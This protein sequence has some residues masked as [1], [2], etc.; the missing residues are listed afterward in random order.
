MPGYLNVIEIPTIKAYSQMLLNC[1]EHI[2]DSVFHLSFLIHFTH[3]NFDMVICDCLR[4]TGEKY[5]GQQETKLR[6]LPPLQ[7]NDQQQR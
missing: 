1:Y 3:H 7:P 5:Q 4:H 2:T 6:R